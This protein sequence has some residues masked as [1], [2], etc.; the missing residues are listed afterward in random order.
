MYSNVLRGIAFNTVLALLQQSDRQ[1]NP[2]K[3]TFA[4]HTF[5]H[6]KPWMAAGILAL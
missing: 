5:N 1:I 6:Y 3:S 4:I 2:S